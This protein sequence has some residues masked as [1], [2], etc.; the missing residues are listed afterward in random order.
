MLVTHASCDTVLP[1]KPLEILVWLRIILP[2]LLHN[3]L[4][5]IAEV[6]LH[7][8]CNLQLILRRNIDSLSTL[9]HQVQYELGDVASGDGDVLNGTSD[10]VPFCTRDN[11]RDTV[12]GIND[13]ASESAVC[14]SVR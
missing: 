6:L 13:C 7:F 9:S 12:S 14:D 4:T 5:H 2:E 1:I 10:D 11:V 3:V 8:P